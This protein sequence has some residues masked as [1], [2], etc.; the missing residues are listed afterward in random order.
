[1]ARGREL[2]AQGI[3]SK[4]REDTRWKEIESGAIKMPREPRTLHVLTGSGI[5]SG[6]RHDCRRLPP[7]GD[8]HAV[9]DA[10]DHGA[11]DPSRARRAVADVSG[12]AHGAHH[13]QPATAAQVADVGAAGNADAAGVVLVEGPSHH[14]QGI[15]VEDGILWVTSVDRATRAGYPRRATTW[16]L[17]AGW[18]AS[19]CTTARGFTPAASRSTATAVWVPVAEYRRSSSTWIQRRDKVTLA[20]LRSSRSPITSA[21]W[22]SPR[23]WSGAATGTARTCI[24]G[25]STA[26]SST[27]ARIRR[28]RSTR[29][30]RSSRA[31]WSPRAWAVPTKGAIDWVDPTTLAVTRRIV[32]GATDRGVPYTNEGMTVRGGSLYLLPEDD[33]SR[34]FRYRLP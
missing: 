13:D 5:R 20:L 4:E 34:L 29:T 24:A 32:T 12:H 10:G 11:A 9:C 7:V 21:A 19:R 33:P 2:V 18:P 14:V 27:S 16:R 15:D 1:M 3:K 23:A 25:G 17:D 22:L 30:S 26:R 8:L 6:H 28:A 31:S